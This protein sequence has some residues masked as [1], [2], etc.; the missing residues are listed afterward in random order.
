[1]NSILIIYTSFIETLSLV[2]VCVFVVLWVFFL[3]GG[4]F[5]I[6]WGSQNCCSW[7]LFPKNFNSKGN[8]MSCRIAF[9]TSY[10]TENEVRNLQNGDVHLAQIVDFGVKYLENHMTHSGQ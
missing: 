8:S 10:L 5:C 4:I 6:R 2:R 9:V 7:K 1:M 3:G